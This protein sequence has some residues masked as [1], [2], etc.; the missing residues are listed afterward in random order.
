M[1]SFKSHVIQGTLVTFAVFRLNVYTRWVKYYRT[2][3]VR[4]FSRNS[5]FSVAA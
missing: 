3:I 4:E 5:L 1:K 2:E